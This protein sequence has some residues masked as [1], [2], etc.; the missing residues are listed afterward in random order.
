MQ[1]AYNSLETFYDDKI[2]TVTI[3]DEQ[4]RKYDASEDDVGSFVNIPRSLETAIVSMSFRELCDGS[5]KVSIRS[6]LVDVANLAR[7]YG[8]GGHERAAGC[9]VKGTLEDVKKKL[10]LEAERRIKLEVRIR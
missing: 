2:A 6:Q 5:V 9:T 4:M 7:Q 8:G 1:V 10:I 3:N